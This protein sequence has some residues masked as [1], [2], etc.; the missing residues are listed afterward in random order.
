MRDQVGARYTAALQKYVTTPYIE[1]YNTS[2]YAQYTIQVDRREAFQ[3]QLKAA[4]VPTAVHYPIPLHL[5]PA[6]SYLGLGEGTF[7]V[8]EAAAQRVLS[9]PLSPWITGEDQELVIHAVSSIA[10]EEGI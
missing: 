10:K 5:Q 2:V 9:L 1:S 3:E 4:G 6:F 7:Q 8:A